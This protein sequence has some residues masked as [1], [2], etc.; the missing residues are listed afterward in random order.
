M[1]NNYAERD[2]PLQLELGLESASLKLKIV[3]H[4]IF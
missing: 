1:L 2:R 4:I 3:E